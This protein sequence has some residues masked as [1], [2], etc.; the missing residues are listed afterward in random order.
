[1]PTR[2]RWCFDVLSPFAWLQW[3]RLHALG[4]QQQMDLRP[5][6]LGA[7]LQHHGQL[8][9]AEIPAKRRFTYRHVCWLAAQQKVPLRFPPLHPFNPLA[10]LR[11]IVAAGCTVTSVDVVLGAVWAE[12]RAVDTAESLAD[13]GRALGIEDVG[14][15]IA[16]PSVKSKLAEFGAEALAEG[17][18]GVPTIVD[19]GQLFWGLDATDLYLEFRAD[20]DLFERPM[21]NGLDDVRS[22]I[23]RKR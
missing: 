1:M 2:P 13:A 20:P 17:V 15:A 12:G 3:R 23:E 6:L 14:A 11:L 22:G 7:L 19:R 4:L 10:A 18:F 5:V 8:G 16:D 21:F 9:P